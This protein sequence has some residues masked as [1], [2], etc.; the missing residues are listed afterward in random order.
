METS[1]HLENLTCEFVVCKSKDQKQLEAQGC[2][3]QGQ[4]LLSK[5]E[6][7]INKPCYCGRQNKEKS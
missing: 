5:H 4:E 7:D 2:I 1:V 3:F 6:L